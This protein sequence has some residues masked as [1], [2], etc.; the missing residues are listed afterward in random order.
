M[1]SAR[2]SPTLSSHASSAQSLLWRF[3]AFGALALALDLGTK[4]W[5]VRTLVDG[6]VLVTSHLALLLVFNTGIAGGASLGPYT[7]LLN[8][9]GTTAA[10]VLVSSVL[11]PLAR[12]DRR[13]ILALGLIAGGA[14]GNLSSLLFESRGVPDFLAVR[15]PDAAIVFNIADVALWSG[16]ILLVPITFALLRAIRAEKQRTRQAH[17]LSVVGRAQSRI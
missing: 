9:V 7:W 3:A 10:L 16:A 11:V 13:A 17:E 6:G 14:A 1:R 8:V 5:A 12:E 15:L 2:I 4:Y